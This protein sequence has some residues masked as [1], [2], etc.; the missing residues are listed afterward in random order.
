M[1]RVSAGVWLLALLCPP[2]RAADPPLRTAIRA[3]RLID[4]RGDRPIAPVIVLIEN[5]RIVQVGGSGEIP[6]ERGSSTSAGRP[7]FRA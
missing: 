7:S 3:A 4:G 2:A 6:R 5:D 1:K